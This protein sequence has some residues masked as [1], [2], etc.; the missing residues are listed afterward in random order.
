MAEFVKVM[1]DYTRMCRQHYPWCDNCPFGLDFESKQGCRDFLI[2]NPRSSEESIEQW[3]AEHPDTNAIR[4][5]LRKCADGK[6]DS[7]CL[8]DGQDHCL[9]HLMQAAAEVI[10]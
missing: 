9:N 4:T 6:C 10:K 2:V 8:F 3:A 7:T 5:A 1:S